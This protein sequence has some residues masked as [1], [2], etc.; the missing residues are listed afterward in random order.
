MP[1]GRARRDG[2]VGFVESAALGS[3]RRGPDPQRQRHPHLRLRRAE[4][5]VAGAGALFDQLAGRRRGPR[6]ASSARRNS[7]W[8]VEAHL[9]PHRGVRDRSGGGGRSSSWARPIWWGGR[10]ARAWGWTVRA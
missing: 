10:G 9:A 3:G 1:G 4:H 8:F 5:Q 6:G 7:G 2:Y